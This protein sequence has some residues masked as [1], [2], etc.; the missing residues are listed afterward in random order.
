VSKTTSLMLLLLV[1]PA[2]ASVPPAGL[3]EITSESLARKTRFSLNPELPHGK[4][5][6]PPG[7]N[8]AKKLTSDDA[9]L[10]ALW[11]NPQFGADLASLG[12]L[13]GDWIDAGQLRNPRLDVLAGLGLKPLE[14]LLNLPIEAIW[15]RPQRLAA[16]EFAYKSLAENLVQNGLLVV[17]AARVAHANFVL[18]H[19]REQILKN[20]TELRRRI[21]K[22]T[23]RE[24]VSTGQLSPA[25]GIATEVES[26]AAEELWVRARHDTLI[27]TERLR[28]ALGLMMNESPL[29][30]NLDEPLDLRIEPVKELEGRALQARPDLKALELGVEAAARRAGWEEARIAQL[31][32]L[33]SSKEVGANGLLTGPGLSFEV[34]LFHLN[35]GRRERADAD[36]ELAALQLLARRERVVFETREARELLAQAIEVLRRTQENVLPLVERTV[37]LAERDYR[38]GAA[39]YLFVLEQTRSLVDAQ[40]READS[41]AA[42]T[43]A[44]A[45]LKRALGEG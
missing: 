43:R 24:R 10:I 39:S 9:A 41:I 31:S 8:L 14:L 45:Q 12:L 30:V 33:L 7:I 6:L 4:P 38:R 40:L 2:C 42:V 5:R 11:G 16:A 28:L 29:T 36:V 44:R 25:E 1:L 32:L 3:S 22:M 18:A 23:S 35:Q 27:E 21:A 17:E 19:R 37:N 26:A 20:T 15:E 13:R 34:P